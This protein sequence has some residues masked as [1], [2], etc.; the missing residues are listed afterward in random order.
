MGKGLVY[1]ISIFLIV[2]VF[3][4]LSLF[5]VGQMDK[6]LLYT[7]PQPDGEVLIYKLDEL[8]SL[9]MQ[10]MG[11]E[12]QLVR[13]SSGITF[14][15]SDAGFPFVPAGSGRV[16]VSKLKTWAESVSGWQNATNSSLKMDVS[17]P[18]ST[19]LLL[20]S[21]G[22]KL[23]YT[24]DNTESTRDNASLSLP[25]AYAPSSVRVDMF[26][27]RPGAGGAPAYTA[28]VGGVGSMTGTINFRDSGG[29]SY[30]S[31]VA[32]DPGTSNSFRAR[33]TGGSGFVEDIHI[34]WLSN[35][36]LQI[37]DTASGG[38]P[39]SDKTGVSCAWNISA[40]TAYPGGA[41]AE[42]LYVPIHVIL[43]STNA[44]YSG[45]LTLAR[46]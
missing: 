37:W 7:Q 19:G 44:N 2:A 22:S 8:A 12:A 15:A 18:S 42:T 27:K 46:K 45:N 34:D 40:T 5:W 38:S 41:G 13:T 30:S 28:W 21:S 29:A 1:T 4:E 24:H 9:S 35:D 31:S 14:N 3:L 33:Y 10:A 23:N 39:A 32:F 25:M 43:N 36:T 6:R 16:Q 20:V 26:C 11:L 17:L